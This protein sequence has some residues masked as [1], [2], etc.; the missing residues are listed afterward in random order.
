MAENRAAFNDGQTR[1]DDKHAASLIGIIGDDSQTLEQKIESIKSHPTLP[2][3]WKTKGINHLAGRFGAE[4]VLTIASGGIMPDSTARFDDGSQASTT[5]GSGDVAKKVRTIAHP[6][7]GENTIDHDEFMAKPYVHWRAANTLQPNMRPEIP[8]SDVIMEMGEAV[9]RRELN[10]TQKAEN[11]EAELEQKHFDQKLAAQR[12]N[13]VLQD[14]GKAPIADPFASSD[15]PKEKDPRD[16][17]PVIGGPTESPKMGTKDF[18]RM[19][20]EAHQI[21]HTHA[22]SVASL[23]DAEPLASTIAD[24]AL[25]HLRTAKRLQDEGDALQSKMNTVAA[26]QMY[27]K[28]L[29]SLTEAHDLMGVDLVKTAAQRNNLTS[30]LP[31]E[32]LTKLAIA[33]KTLNFP[34][35]SRPHKFVNIAGKNVDPFEYD[36]KTVA[37]TIGQESLVYRKLAKGQSGSQK[38]TTYEG[39]TADPRAKARADMTV[40][41]RLGMAAN[42]PS[43]PDNRIIRDIPEGRTSGFGPK[44]NVG[45]TTRTPSPTRARITGVTL[46]DKS[47]KPITTSEGKPIMAPGVVKPGVAPKESPFTPVKKKYDINGKEIQPPVQGPRMLFGNLEPVDELI[48]SER[49]TDRD[50]RIRNVRAATNAATAEDATRGAVAARTGRPIAPAPLRMAK[51]EEYDVPS[52]RAKLMAE[53]TPKELAEKATNLMR[54]IE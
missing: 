53:F 32:H 54:G 6:R 41:T 31:S 28:S 50:N 25:P 8:H 36:L 17:R 4:K 44:P 46:T 18:S 3:T 10:S 21:L 33:T 14:N 20:G 23:R 27:A 49:I 40:D 43:T 5:S 13:K 15:T 35:P 7:N 38:G 51:S 2:H 52:R 9:G 34:K 24:F 26:G 22:T 47:G 45:A 39:R 48:T 11:A 30:E 1:D 42:I 16:R 37:R 19:L 12:I 29:D